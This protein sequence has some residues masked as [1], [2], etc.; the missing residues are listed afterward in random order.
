MTL[1]YWSHSFHPQLLPATPWEL[2]GRLSADPEKQHKDPRSEKTLLE[3]TALG[4]P[5]FRAL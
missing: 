1:P 3:R 5:G 2:L 4:T